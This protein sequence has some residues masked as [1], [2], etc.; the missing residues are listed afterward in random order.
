[1]A[2]A[3]ALREDCVFCQIINKQSPAWV[4]YEDEEVICFLPKKCE[5]Y[6]HT[7]VV[8]KLH[9]ASLYDIPEAIL[10][11]LIKVVRKVTLAYKKRINATGMNVLHAS[12]VDAQQSVPHFHF[13]L[14][15]RFKDDQLNTWPSLPEVEVNKEELWQKLRIS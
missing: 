7:L 6:G 5:V 10:C 9:Y 12:G 4:V 11:E 13:H 15:P 8:P 1:M 3:G 2:R 14:L